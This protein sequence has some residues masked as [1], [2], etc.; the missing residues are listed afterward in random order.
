VDSGASIALG[1]RWNA[2]SNVAFLAMFL[3]LLPWRSPRGA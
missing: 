1:F 2:L 3:V